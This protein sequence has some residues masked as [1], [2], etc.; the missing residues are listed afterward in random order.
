MSGE[1]PPV[2]LRRAINSDILCRES[3]YDSFKVHG[4][5]WPS[6]KTCY[7]SRI[8][9]AF[10]EC[11]PV[12]DFNPYI[13]TLCEFYA[14]LIIDA[15]DNTGFNWVMRVLSSVETKPEAD[16]PQALLEE[17][18]SKRTG[19]RSITH[20]FFKSESRPPMRRVG[21][22]SGPDMLGSRI[23][24]VAQD[25]F[26]K[27]AN[28][29][30]AALL[31]DDICNTG[32]SMR[33]YAYALK[34]YAGVEAVYCMNLAATRFRRGKDGYG[35]LKLDTSTLSDN[36]QFAQVWL[37]NSGAFHTRSDCRQAQPPLCCEIRFLAQRN[38]KPCPECV[39][40]DKSPRKWWQ[41]IFERNGR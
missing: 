31:I 18:I 24:Y 41:V 28:L 21:H 15:I 5:F 26:I 25:L 14:K 3:P 6:S 33:V 23:Q 9:K 32:A 35:M 8:V 7:E 39:E 37:D 34:A 38:A 22:L 10:K 17:I 11:R 36:P 27:P 19:A 12:N 29:G 40:K 1:L 13:S 2:A 4:S 16:R 20:L 30:G